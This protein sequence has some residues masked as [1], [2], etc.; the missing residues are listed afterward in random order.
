QPWFPLV[1]PPCQLLAMSHRAS[2]SLATRRTSDLGTYTVIV[3]TVDG[4]GGNDNSGNYLLTLAK[5]PGAIETSSGDEGGTLT[6][7]TTY[8]SADDHA[9]D[10][11]SRCA[12]A[13][14]DYI[15]MSRGEVAPAS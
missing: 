12:A 15:A 7:G 10:H 11:A 9:S 6:N 1:S 14:R 5:G 2:P 3:G 13:Q 8:A 4:L